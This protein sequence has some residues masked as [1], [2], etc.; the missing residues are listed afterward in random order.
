M[1]TP[2]NRGIV[3]ALFE[4]GKKKKEIARILG[5]DPKE[6]SGADSGRESR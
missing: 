3:R 5:I 2:E 6:A 4:Q 1:I